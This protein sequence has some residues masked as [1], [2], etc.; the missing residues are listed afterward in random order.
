MGIPNSQTSGTSFLSSSIAKVLGIR[1]KRLYA[2]LWM[3]VF[4]FEEGRSNGDRKYEGCWF[5]PKPYIH[6]KRRVC[7]HRL[8]L[9][10]NLR[11]L[12]LFSQNRLPL[13]LAKRK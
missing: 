5:A 9:L 7:G 8:G 6:Y 12:E 13:L 3:K 2:T 1:G 11:Q 4:V 10:V